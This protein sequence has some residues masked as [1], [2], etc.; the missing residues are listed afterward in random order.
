M[1]SFDIDFDISN[2]WKGG[3]TANMAITNNSDSQLNGWTI[4]FEFPYEISKI[5]NAEIVSHEGNR[6]TISNL[7]WNDTIS[8]NETVSFGFKAD[9]GNI[10]TEPG[11]YLLNGESLSTSPLLPTPSID[12]VNVSE[13]NSDTTLVSSEPVTLWSGGFNNHNWENNWGFEDF[14]EWGLQNTTELTDSSGKFGSLL[15]VDYPEGS[16]APSV[17]RNEGAALGGAQFYAD[18][19]VPGKDSLRLSYYVRFAEDFDFVKGG[20]LPGLYGGTGASGGNIPDGTDGFSTRFMWRGDG[21]GEV[22]AY[23]PTTEKYGTSLGRGN[24]KFQPGTWHYLEQ[25]INLNDPGKANGE[26]QVLLD[27]KSVLDQEGLTFRTT[28]KLKID[29]IFFSTFFGGGDSSWATP[30]DTHIDFADF[31]VSAVSPE[32]GFSTTSAKAEPNTD[33][34]FI[35]A[36]VSESDEHSTTINVEIHNNSN[37]TDQSS[38]D[39]SF[40]YFVDLSELYNAGGTANDVSVSSNSTEGQLSELTPWD[41]EQHLYYVEMDFTGTEIYPNSSNSLLQEAQISLGL[42][43]SLPDAAWNATNDWSYQNLSLGSEL[44]TTSHIPLYESGTNLLVGELPV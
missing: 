15:R 42:S 29:G 4:E 1:N 11:N 24:W 10:T 19:G 23:L 9:S 44:S 31:S 28:D 27:G 43:S 34:F 6:Y 22:Y 30:Q 38:S 7:S 13:G 16:A 8:P 32:A 36:A 3:S 41:T 40:R 2:A 20:K 12:D 14:G 37:S 17:S 33:D 35:Q 25:E 18:L 5:W 39:L 21:D 26:L